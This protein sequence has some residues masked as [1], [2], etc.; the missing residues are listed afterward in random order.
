MTDAGKQAV[1]AS[2]QN[3]LW[4]FMD[5]VDQLI[6]PADFLQSLEAQPPAL[7]N[8]DAFGAASKRFMLRHI[9]IAKTPATRAKRIEEITALAKLG[10]KLPGS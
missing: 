5:D 3:G 1:L 4:D 9:K 6:K 10:K 2:K 8:F 7:Q